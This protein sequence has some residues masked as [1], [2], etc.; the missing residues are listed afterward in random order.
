MADSRLIPDQYLGF[1]EMHI[2]QGPAMWEAGEGLAI[3]TAIAGRKQYLA[4]IAG[5]SNHAGSTPMLFRSDALVAAARVVVG[6]EQMARSLSDQTVATVGRIEC[7]PNSIN[8]IPGAVRFTIDLRSA[9]ADLLA[10]GHQQIEQM[11][12]STGLPNTLQLTE[13]QAPVQMN[14]SLCSRLLPRRRPAD[15]RDDQRRAPRRRDHRTAHPHRGGICC[16]QERHQ[17]PSRRIQSK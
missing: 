15:L 7:K 11:I 9:D 5:T 1:I 16:Q 10:A 4:N 8:V 14:S 17:P 2:E 3:V 12:A 13:D 6:V